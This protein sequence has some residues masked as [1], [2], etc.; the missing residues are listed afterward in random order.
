MYMRRRE[1]GAEHALITGQTID[2]RAGNNDVRADPWPDRSAPRSVE[3]RV[4]PICP[5]KSFPEIRFL[6]NSSLGRKA[7]QLKLKLPFWPY[8][9]G[10]ASAQTSF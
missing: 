6:K 5:R 7:A 8:G 2:D 9:S 3:A 10:H 4:G 1:R